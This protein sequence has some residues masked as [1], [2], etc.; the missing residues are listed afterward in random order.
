MEEILELAEEIMESRRETNPDDI[1]K[2]VEPY[3][4]ELGL[5]NDNFMLCITFDRFY[6]HDNSCDYRLYVRPNKANGIYKV[7]FQRW[8]NGNV[9][10]DV[11][12]RNNE[13]SNECLFEIHKC[14]VE[15]AEKE[16]IEFTSEIDYENIVKE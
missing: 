9:F 13:L 5:Q 12:S 14:I 1:S 8:A 15:L 16:G 2:H 7:I 3:P 10:I 4:D 6:G 11:D